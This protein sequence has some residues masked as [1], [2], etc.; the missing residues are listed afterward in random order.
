MYIK[1]KNVKT[2]EWATLPYY[3][4]TAAS[5]GFALWGFGTSDAGKSTVRLAI[6]AVLMFISR[7]FDT[8]S[9]YIA[10]RDGMNNHIIHGYCEHCGSGVS[11]IKMKISA[12]PTVAVIVYECGAERTIEAEYN[13]E[14]KRTSMI[15]NEESTVCG[16]SGERNDEI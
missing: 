7:A 12:S 13:D 1:F 8:T 10:V 2:M 6:G 4:M 3:V 9:V 11:H 15:L 16:I 14:A 5:F